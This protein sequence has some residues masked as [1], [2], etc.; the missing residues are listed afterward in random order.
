MAAVVRPHTNLCLLPS[1]P[2]SL[3]PSP[4]SLLPPGLAPHPS[5]GGWKSGEAF[6]IG[7][8]IN[9]R[10]RGGGW[11]CCLRVLRVLG[12]RLGCARAGERGFRKLRIYINSSFHSQTR[13]LEKEKKK[14][15]K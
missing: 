15:R 3:L 4:S 14:K 7:I 5:M 2:S 10:I 12:S 13:N 1:P 11:W 9:S 8:R 6:R